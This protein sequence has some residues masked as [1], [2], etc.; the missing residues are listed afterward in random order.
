MINSSCFEDGMMLATHSNVDRIIRFIAGKPV[1]D[2]AHSSYALAI[3]R[4]KRFLKRDERGGNG[5]NVGEWEC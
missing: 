1:V 2:K 4:V 5:F 3:E